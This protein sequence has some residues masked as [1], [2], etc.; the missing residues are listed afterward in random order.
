[1]IG[2]AQPKY[3]HSLLETHFAERV[4]FWVLLLDK[5]KWV[6]NPLSITLPKH[7]MGL[8]F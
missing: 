6:L 2:E 5:Q 7:R 1:M 3:E 4:L 8:L